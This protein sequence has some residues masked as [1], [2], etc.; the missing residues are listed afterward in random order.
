MP[1]LT[2][3]GKSVEKLEEKIKELEDKHRALFESMTL[4]ERGMDHPDIPV[5]IRSNMINPCVNFIVK[6]LKHWDKKKQALLIKKTK[7]EGKK[8]YR[9]YI[10]DN[11]KPSTQRAKDIQNG[12]RF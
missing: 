12:K 1:E 8:T 10:T 4:F 2:P 3:A 7:I 6:K 9:Q 5:D 11:V